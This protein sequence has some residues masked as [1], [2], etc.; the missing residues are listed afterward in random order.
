MKNGFFTNVSFSPSDE[1][2]TDTNRFFKD[3][4]KLVKFIDEV[5]DKYDDH[6]SIYYTDNIYRFFRNI[7]RENR[8]EHGRGAKDFNNFL[9]YEGENC[10]TP[11]GHGCFLKCINHNFEKD[12]C[13][14]FFEFIQS[15][16]RKALVMARCEFRE[17]RE[18]YEIHVGIFD[19]KSKRILPKS[20][21]QRD[22]CVYIQKKI[23]F[24]L[25]GRRIE[26][27]FT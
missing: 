3:S 22:I 23:I 15:Y 27:Y 10:F 25:F 9:E 11:N 19:T 5:L 6:P 13:M 17:F 4:K 21:K 12:F 7:K 8:S 26:N 20:V 14:K 18:R 2:E 16:K 24:V 1:G